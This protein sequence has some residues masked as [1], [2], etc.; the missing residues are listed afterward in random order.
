MI[1]FVIGTEKPYQ[2]RQC[3]SV[4]LQVKCQI[5]SSAVPRVENEKLKTF[6]N[7][8]TWPRTS[9]SCLESSEC[10]ESSSL[11]YRFIKNMK[12]NN[13]EKSV[14]IIKKKEALLV[15]IL[16]DVSINTSHKLQFVSKRKN[17]KV[18]FD[19]SDTLHLYKNISL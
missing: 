18:R 11:R 8:K 10:R 19:H 5:L 14:N 3:C 4:Y 15:D 2:G 7:I 6:T 1:V 13:S 17:V 9:L 16:S 12:W